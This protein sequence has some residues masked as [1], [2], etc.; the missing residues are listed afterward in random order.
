MQAKGKINFLLLLTS[1]F[2]VAVIVASFIQV[3]LVQKTLIS[4]GSSGSNASLSALSTA[5]EPMQ[6]TSPEHNIILQRNNIPIISTDKLAPSIP[7]PSAVANV[8]IPS[9][10]LPI[11]STSDNQLEERAVQ[12]DMPL[13]INAPMTD[14]QILE[15]IKAQNQKKEALQAILAKRDRTAG[16]VRSIV[17]DMQKIQ[18]VPEQKMPSDFVKTYPPP[19]VVSK[20]KSNKLTAH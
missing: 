5:K 2:T 7:K 11:Q 4:T 9:G 3:R 14:E 13:I 17:S 1:I 8:A 10:P 12:V 20:L 16:Q 6:K 19:D 18:P 15:S